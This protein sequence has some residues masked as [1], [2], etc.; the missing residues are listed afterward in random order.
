MLLACVRLNRLF[1]HGEADRGS[2]GGRR[3]ELKGQTRPTCV[4][5]CMSIGGAL[6]AV[7]RSGVK[8]W[9]VAEER[10]ETTAFVSAR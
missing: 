9:V 4:Y 3:E 10:E 7:K 8:V 6:V 5:V 1:L 2:D